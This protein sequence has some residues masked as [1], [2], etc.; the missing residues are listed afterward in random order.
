MRIAL[1]LVISL[2]VIG[3]A[4][5][6]GKPLLV[7]D[8]NSTVGNMLTGQVIDDSFA[9]N[10]CNDDRDCRVGRAC[11]DGLCEVKNDE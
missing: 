4:V 10:Y 2:L 1:I 8:S 7:N 11:V 6:P 3:C 5:R 9:N